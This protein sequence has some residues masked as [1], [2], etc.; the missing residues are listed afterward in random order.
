MDARTGIQAMLYLA[1]ALQIVAAVFALV[2]IP[3]SGMRRS[4]IV[5]CIALV[6]Q[7]G[8]RVYVLN[9]HAT[10][11]EALSALAV[12]I[13][14]L[15]GIV[16]IRTVFVSLRRT[17]RLLDREVD[18]GT[19]V[20]NRAGAP[21]VV[22]EPDGRIREVNDA[23]R[24]L[25][26]LDGRDVT[27]IDWFDAFV[28]DDRRSQVRSSFERLVASEGG[29]DE[30]SEAVLRDTDGGEHSIVWHRRVLLDADGHTIGVRSAGLDMTDSTLLEKVLA[31][32]S[33]L[34]D[35]TNDSVLVYR[36]D[37]VV[38][39]ANDTACTY[40][41]VRR[42]DMVGA[43]I[44]RFISVR[45]RD[46]FAVHMDTIASGACVTFE[47]ETVNREGIVRPL[48]VHACPVYLGGDRV[49]VDVARDITERREAEAAIRRM[50]YTDHLTGLP[51]RVLLSDRSA[52]A[53]ARA[54]RNGEHLALL[55]MDLDHVK[56]VNDTLG[57]AAGDE[58][59]R[60]VGQ[61]LMETFRGEDTVARI[62]G[63]E[64]VVLVTVKDEEDAGQVAERL[65]QLMED[66]FVV[67]G[68]EVSSSASVGVALF[69]DHAEILEDL[70]A[71]ADSAMYAAKEQGRDR[72]RMHAPA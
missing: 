23:M 33:L 27:G 17:K 70:I 54:R 50:A 32:R 52:V 62:G 59:L 68:E 11:A 49:V 46:A 20:E 53:I 24:T 34:L 13:L 2:L 3:V 31:F 66:S 28:T 5:I 4:W 57:H 60:Q 63:D 18:R 9:T 43:D 40:R 36:F 47:T 1:A 10:W 8:R 38:V 58:L 26:R 22:L 61:R 72:Y 67:G 12:S 45:D 37:G 15:A 39:Y 44:R 42:E 69:P 71:L 41:G 48:E 25:L 21:I 6:I 30:Y 51:N 14:L 65:V 56:V 55:F 35:H 64:F 7:A 29:N 16:G 19:V